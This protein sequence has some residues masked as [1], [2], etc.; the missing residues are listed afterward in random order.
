MARHAVF[1]SEH[2][3][4]YLIE[5]ENTYSSYDKLPFRYV[6]YICKVGTYTHDTSTQHFKNCWN[7]CWRTYKCLYFLNLHLDFFMI[8]IRILFSFVYLIYL[9]KSKKIRNEYDIGILK[10]KLNFCRTIHF[11]NVHEHITDNFDSFVKNKHKW[12][13]PSE[14]EAESSCLRRHCLYF[15]L[16]LKCKR[17]LNDNEMPSSV[18]TPRVCAYILRIRALRMFS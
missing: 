7:E 12:N 15:H 3:K 18:S 16:Y 4:K 1:P 8:L 10:L 17:L 13:E 11:W 2:P 6:K 5:E 14:A 9:Q